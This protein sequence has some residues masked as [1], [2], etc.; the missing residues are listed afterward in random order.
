MRII[1]PV[2]HRTEYNTNRTIP[3]GLA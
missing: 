1:R 2:N 3:V